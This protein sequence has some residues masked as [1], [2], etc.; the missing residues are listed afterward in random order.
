M[1]LFSKKAPKVEVDDDH[2]I[3]PHDEMK[4]F[5]GFYFVPDENDYEDNCKIAFFKI[6]E[7]MII[8]VI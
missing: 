6:K 5:D 7:L 8:N 1:S 2:E 4:D 3:V